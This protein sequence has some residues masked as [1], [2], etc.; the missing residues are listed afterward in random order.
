MIN[1][2]N[3]SKANGFY[4]NGISAA[5][6]AFATHDQINLKAV[7]AIV[8]T[9]MKTGFQKNADVID[10]SHLYQMQATGRKAP[11]LLEPLTQEVVNTANQVRSFNRTSMTNR[12]QMNFEQ[13]GGFVVDDFNTI[14]SQVIMEVYDNS[15]ETALA[16]I[17]PFSQYPAAKVVV[18]VFAA[19]GGLIAPYKYG[20]PVQEV[21]KIGN[22]TYEYSGIPYRNYITIDERELTFWRELGNPNISARGLLQ[23]L[24]MYSMQ[25]K[26]I[27]NNRINSIRSTIFANGINY[28]NDSNALTTVSY[29]IP[30]YNQVTSITDPVNEWGTVYTQTN[31]IVPN[32][33]ANPIFDLY[34]YTKLYLAWISKFQRIRRCKLIM[35]PVTEALILQNPNVSSQIAIIQ[36]QPGS[37]VDARG[38]RT[39]EFAIKTQIPGLEIEVLVDGSSYLLQNSDVT[40][41]PSGAGF[42]TTPVAQQFFIP[43]GAIMFAIDV[44]DK[45]GRLGEFVFTTSVQNGGFI[46]ANASPWFI[47]E[48]LTAPGT[49]GG[50][51][52]PSVQ[53]DFG[54]AGGLQPYHPEA[55]LLGNFAVLVDAPGPLAEPES[56]MSFVQASGNGGAKR[57]SIKDKK[58]TITDVKTSGT[59]GKS[60]ITDQRV[61]RL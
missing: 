53:L 58:A 41:Q 8:E 5:E 33:L 10:Y 16:A 59:N 6:A 17:Y 52:N 57:V 45:G 28:Y 11:F 49:R 15:A 54:F 36:A 18:E 47:I 23:R 20:E 38:F 34:Y 50:P 22:R 24:T 21:P 2:P 12:K 27:T 13:Q 44:E 51:L 31:R 7:D 39:A 9:L 30:V 4:T 55:T 61:E 35:S 25:A 43:P 56:I 42:T 40:W 3:V 19:P 29:Q 60:V 37:A 14:I 46:Q 26:V 1:N 32:P 48:D